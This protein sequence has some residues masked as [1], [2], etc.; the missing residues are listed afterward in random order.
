MNKDV[1]SKQQLEM[2]ITAIR[3]EAIADII[4]WKKYLPATDIRKSHEELY[5]APMQWYHIPG[6]GNYNSFELKFH[7]DWNWLMSCVLEMKK[8]YGID[9]PESKLC[10][11]F[12]QIHCTPILYL[13]MKKLWMAVS[14][15]CMELL[16]Q[17]REEKI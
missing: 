9:K 13:D 6:I 14:D 7:S 15:Y 5:K 11:Y 1:V 3:N 2:I 16:K 17:K 4:G 8:Y 10:S 12:N